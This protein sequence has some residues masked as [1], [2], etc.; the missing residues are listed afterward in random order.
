MRLA[1]EAGIGFAFPSRTTYI[2]LDEVPSLAARV[3]AG[4]RSQNVGDRSG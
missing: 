1:D 4:R 3:A 2:N